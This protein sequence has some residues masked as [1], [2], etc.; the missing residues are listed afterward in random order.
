MKQLL[1]LL[2]L[3][4]SLHV[5]AQQDTLAINPALQKKYLIPE[6][7]TAYIGMPAEQL[8]AATMKKDILDNYVKTFAKGT[9]KQITFQVTTSNP[10][11][12]EFIIEY[13]PAFNLTAFIT[14]KYG[15][16]NSSDAMGNVW[17]APL[18]DGLKLR[19][20]KYKNKLCIA[21]ARQFTE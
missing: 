6:L 11:V 16:P 14:K 3:I 5:T 13:S 12:Y 7:G 4:T 10:Q 1:I 21:D 15:T 17:M 20:W 18:A 9:I 8:P 2:L 19:I